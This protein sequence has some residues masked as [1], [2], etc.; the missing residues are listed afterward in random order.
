M[1]ALQWILAA[2]CV[3]TPLVALHEWG[4]YI[5]ARMCGVKVLT[6]SI[7]FGKR[8][9]GW[10]SPKTGI[11]YKVCAI[12]LGGYVRMLDEREGD[13]PADEQH[14][15]FNRQHPLKKIAIVAAGPAM[16]L[17][18][19]VA[20]FFVLFMTPSE[21][22]NTRIGVIAPESPAAA[23]TLVAGE[24]I[25]A[26]DGRAVQTWEAV[27]Y[28]LADRMGETGE[29]TITTE[30]ANDLVASDWA[31]KDIKAEP[32]STGTSPD[33]ISKDVILKSEQAASQT[34]H[35]IA[36]HEFMQGEQKGMG[37]LESLGV[38]PFQPVIKPVIGKVV[39]EGAADLMGLKAGDEVL[40][41]DD[42]KITHWLEAATIIR[43]NP[44]T[45][46][47]FLVLRD[48]REISLDVM[49]QGVKNGSERIGQIGVRVAYDGESA[50]PSEYR[51]T[52]SHT[53]KEAMV[54]AFERTYQLTATTFASIG[55]MITGMIGLDN[56][57]GPIT[58]AEVS[59]TSFE[60]GWQQVLST[61]AIISLSLAVMNLLPIPVLDGGHLLF[62]LYELI[63]RKPISERVQMAGIRLGMSLLLCF[64]VL[65]IVNDVL[66]LFG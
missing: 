18:I 62:Y 26:I 35:R 41:I 57:S 24:K 6:Y 11:E 42:K 4:H 51:M 17:L 48:G 44:E 2:L 28:A 5:V 56:L 66:R 54:R 29:I 55:K 20:L 25:I 32:S 49:P 33:T 13:V 7:G 43:S 53:P 12:P 30:T 9:F 39:P 38:L 52:V 46:L 65:A 47:K 1:T 14:K 15:A 59:K 45:M 36:V 60:I 22:L 31:A 27:N 63:F 10:T 37:A 23:S 34:T 58:I 19:A 64:M 61:A 40:A 3:L 16:N 21:Q 50:V 8:L